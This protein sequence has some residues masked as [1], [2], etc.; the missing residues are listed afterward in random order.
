MRTTLVTRP[1]ADFDRLFR[2]RWTVAPDHGVGFP[3][4]A[5]IRREAG[6]LGASRELRGIDPADITVEVEGRHLVIRGER[7]DE[8][9]E[10]SDGRRIRE[11]R[12]GTFARSVT[13]P[14]TA[15]ADS[16]SARYDAGV[17]T[18]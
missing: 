4:A 7:K 18:V 10:S 14:K 16:I 12:Y 3:P 8:H 17:L 13:L 9:T 2:D 5:A 1:F 6:A 11:V 15:D